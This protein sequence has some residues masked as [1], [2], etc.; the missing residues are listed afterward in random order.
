MNRQILIII[1]KQITIFQ[2]RRINRLESNR[3]LIGFV[4]ITQV[5]IEQFTPIDLLPTLSL[6]M[7]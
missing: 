6:K 7:F 5:N 4:F 3:I 2:R 1:G